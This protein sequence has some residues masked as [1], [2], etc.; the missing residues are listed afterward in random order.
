MFRRQGVFHGNL[1]RY[2]S[3][4]P[5]SYSFSLDNRIPLLDLNF[6][7]AGFYYNISLAVIP[8]NINCVSIHQHFRILRQIFN[9]NRAV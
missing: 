7:F 4:A 1:E 5:N 9:H 3:T 2:F 8:G 6:S